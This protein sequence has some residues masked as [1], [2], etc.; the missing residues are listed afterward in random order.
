[1]YVKPMNDMVDNFTLMFTEVMLS[2]LS[3]NL[4][5]FTDYILNPVYRY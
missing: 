5:M 3:I 2:L 4:Y 1:M